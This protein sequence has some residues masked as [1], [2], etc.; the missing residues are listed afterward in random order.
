MIKIKGDFYMSIL[1]K[2]IE[3]TTKKKYIDVFKENGCEIFYDIF[4]KR[5]VLYVKIDQV[6]LT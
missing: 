5:K 2:I 4:Q 1:H 6:L 3:I